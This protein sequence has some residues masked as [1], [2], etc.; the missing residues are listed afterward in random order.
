MPAELTAILRKARERGA[1]GHVPF[2]GL[3]TPQ[4]AHT[5]MQAG[6]ATLVDVRTQAE[7][8]WA[9][10]VPGAIAI[11]WQLY[12]GMQ[13]NP[14]F[15]ETLEAHVPKTRPVLFLCRTAGRSHAAAALAT[16][17]GY[18]AYNILE[19]FEGEADA[20]KR[21]ATINGWRVAGLPWQ[22]AR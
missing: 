19:G 6:N 11:P 14:A 2:A 16:Q 7:L 13:K 4:E 15:A 18:E 1:A 21:R 12:P 8:D 3:V 17:M 5:L 10:I 22:H 9:G 20:L